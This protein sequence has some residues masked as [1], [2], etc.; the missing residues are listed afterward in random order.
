MRECTL[1][2]SLLATP[3]FAPLPLE[4]LQRLC[5]PLREVAQLIGLWPRPAIVFAPFW[6]V[7]GNE[8]V[9]ADLRSRYKALIEGWAAS[10]TQ[11]SRSRFFCASG[12]PNRRPAPEPRNWP[13]RLNVADTAGEL[14]ALRRCVC[15]DR[16]SM[17]AFERPWACD[18]TQKY[19]PIPSSNIRLEVS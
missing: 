16:P 13:A 8:A 18:S 7:P 5:A 17:D 11:M 3:P 14:D 1:V 12:G 4:L 2:A 9:A 10:Y 15:R 6:L 19:Q